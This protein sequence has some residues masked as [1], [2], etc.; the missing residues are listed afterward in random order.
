MPTAPKCPWDMLNE[1]PPSLKAKLSTLPKDCDLTTAQ[2]GVTKYA[3]F[4]TRDACGFEDNN[5]TFSSTTVL[6][7][8][9]G[10]R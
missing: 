10:I 4:D 8:L 1:L 6:Q 2:V 7:F 3:L 9:K 5:Y